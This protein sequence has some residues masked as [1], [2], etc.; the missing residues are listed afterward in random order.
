MILKYLNAN[1]TRSLKVV[2]YFTGAV[3]LCIMTG[4]TFDYMAGAWS[5]QVKFILTEHLITHLGFPPSVRDVLS[6]TFIPGFVL[7][8][9]GGSFVGQTKYQLFYQCL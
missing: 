5:H 7:F 9:Y 1:S 4:Y 8:A 2:L 3:L 6:V